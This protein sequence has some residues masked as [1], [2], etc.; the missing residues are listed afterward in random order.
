MQLQRGS[1]DNSFADPIVDLLELCERSPREALEVIYE[2]LS[3]DPNDEIIGYLGAGPLESLL[4]SNCDQFIE[5]LINRSKS[6]RGLLLCLK[7][8]D[9][10]D[11][12]CDMADFFY[13]AIRGLS[14][15]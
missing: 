12:E 1:I 9:L 15:E 8:V 4:V 7:S 14:L 13:D 3:Y 2:I 5:E 10:D 6:S 11:S